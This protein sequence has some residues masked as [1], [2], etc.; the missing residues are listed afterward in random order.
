MNRTRLDAEQVR[1][2]IL[3]LSG[4]LDDSMYGP[5]VMHFTMKP[6][7]GGTPEADYEKFDLDA[8]AS[9]RRSIYR[10]IFRTAPDP[11]LAALDCPE[12]SQSA[13][14]RTVSVGA[15]QALAL[16]NDKFTLRHAEHLAELATKSSKESTGQLRFVTQRLLNRSPVQHEVDG[17]SAYVQKHGLANLCRV[18]FNS[19]EFLFVE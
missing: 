15:L 19:S 13:P 17:W 2:S 14:V 11:L 16:W 3:L 7:F 6:G 9:R 1:D 18:L 10:F 8:P 4:R 5:P 12:A